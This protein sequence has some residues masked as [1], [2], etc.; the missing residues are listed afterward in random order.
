MTNSKLYNLNDMERALDDVLADGFHVIHPEEN[1]NGDCP[2][3]KAVDAACK[4]IRKLKE[5]EDEKQAVIDRQRYIDSFK[6]RAVRCAKGVPAWDI[7]MELHDGT[8][9]N[10]GMV[11]NFP[12]EKSWVCTLR[13]DEANQE[14]ELRHANRDDMFKAIREAIADREDYA[15]QWESEKDAYI[16]EQEAERAALRWAEERYDHMGGYDCPIEAGYETP[17]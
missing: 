9:R 6:L 16:Y 17:F 7:M 5:A 12:M 10:M 13:A 3:Y 1:W 11:S 14:V 8:E 4:L 2:T 15:A